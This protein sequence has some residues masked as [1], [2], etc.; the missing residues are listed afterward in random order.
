MDPLIRNLKSTP[1]FGRRFTRREISDIQETV[2]LFPANTRNELAKTIWE[3]LHGYTPR[4]DYRKDAALRVWEQLEAFGI[5]TLLP[6]RN[7]IAGRRSPLVHTEASDPGE[8]IP[9]TLS[10]LEPLSLA[11]ADTADDKALWRE[12]VDRHH[13]L[14]CPRPFGPSLYGF[15]VDADGRRLGCRL[16]EA[17]S[18]QLPTRD[19]WIGWKAKQREQRLHLVVQNSRFLI[20]PW[21]HVRNLA[22]RVLAMAT[23]QLADEWEQLH[24]CRPVLIETFVDTTRFDGASYKVSLTV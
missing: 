3:H 14:G 11:S 20:L 8:D 21:V 6:K 22:S 1:F 12:L 4:G 13:S 16:M 19:D 10:D 24:K 7:T 18:R 23:S 15:V 5:L 9:C 17:G 2:A